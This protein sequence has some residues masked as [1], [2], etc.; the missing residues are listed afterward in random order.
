MHPISARPVFASLLLIVLAGGAHR[1]SAITVTSP[2]AGSIVPAGDDYASRLLANSWDMSD[3]LDI[4]TQDSSDMTAQTFNSGIFSA[5]TTANLPTV[6]PLF[7]GYIGAINLSQGANS[8]VDTSHYRYVTMKLKANRPGGHAQFAQ[9]GFYKN[10]EAISNQDLG[11]T[12]FSAQLPDN[13]WVILTF[14]MINDNDQ[15]H[16]QWLDFPTVQGLSLLP[17]YSNSPGGFLSVH[18]AIDWLR[19]TAP[20]SPADETTVQWSDSGYIG[21]YNLIATDSD[22]ATYALANGV[23]GPTYAADLTRLGAGQ[24]TVTVTRS[25]GSG[26]PGVSGIFRV[27]QTPQLNIDTPDAEGDLSRDFASTKLN[28]PW[29][30]FSAQDF[31]TNGTSQNGAINFAAGSISYTT[32]PN[33]FYGRPKNNDPAWFFNLGG[34]SIDANIYRSLCFDLEVFGPRSL[35]GGSVA[36]VFWG[37]SLAALTTSETIV[38]D[39][40]AGGTT[41]SRYCIPDLAQVQPEVGTPVSGGTW[42]GTKTYFRIDPDEFTPPNGCGSPNTCHD[43]RLDSVTLSPF[44]QANPGFT[45]HW[46]LAD[47]DDASSTL[48]LYLDPDRDPSNGN[49]ILIHT[50]NASSG[51]GTYAWP[52][53]SSVN[54]GTYNVLMLADDGHNSVSQYAGGPLVVG[55]YDGIFRNGL[56]ALP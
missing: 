49:E 45:F 20:A 11:E 14:D 10:R 52:G 1:A 51:S 30:P 17:T 29:G 19:L 34:M 54:Y 15:I 9:V 31:S 2:T 43:V 7:M 46:T 32:Y 8:P 44:A 6:Y 12:Y 41:V 28:N 39:D 35:G 37:N 50:T 55:A 22:G 13:Q 40:N 36:R 25:D 47:A 23:S 53:S 26:T 38:L 4:H 18:F 27:N 21:T 24:Y 5:D 16:H 3:A 56:D 42:S 33:S 48:D